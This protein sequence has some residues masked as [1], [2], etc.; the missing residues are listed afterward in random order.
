MAVMQLCLIKHSAD[1]E[2]NMRNVV[3]ISRRANRLFLPTHGYL[4]SPGKGECVL[5]FCVSKPIDWLG[6]Q[7]SFPEVV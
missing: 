7:K 1:D 2:N 5:V 4:F 6:V 3:H